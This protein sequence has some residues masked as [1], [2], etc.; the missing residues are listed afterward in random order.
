MLKNM[1]QLLIIEGVPLE[2]LSYIYFARNN[3]YVVSSQVH[4][5]GQLILML[6]YDLFEQLTY[7]CTADN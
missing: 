5:D 1:S 7:P 2:P 6:P 4:L 3:Q